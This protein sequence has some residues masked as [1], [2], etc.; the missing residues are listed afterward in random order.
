MIMWYWVLYPNWGLKAEVK[1]NNKNF[2]ADASRNITEVSVDNDKSQMKLT[3][4]GI[5]GNFAHYAANTVYCSVK[6]RLANI[7]LVSAANSIACNAATRLVG[8]VDLD[9]PILRLRC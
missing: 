4:I 6:A 7:S 8:S 3:D 1:F 5:S 2:Y 9:T